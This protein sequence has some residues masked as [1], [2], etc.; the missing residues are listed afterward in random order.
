M[1]HFEYQ[2]K[3]T[4]GLNLYGQGWTPSGDLKAVVCLIHGIGEHSSRYEHVAAFLSQ[5]GYALFTFD[6]RGHGRSEG[7]HGH[8]PS[9]E[10]AMR[11]VEYHLQ[12]AAERF[13]N[14]PII[15]YG[16]SMGG[17]LVLNYALRYR[18]QIAGV[19]ATAPMLRLS[20]K[21]SRVKQLLAKFLI[22]VWPTLSLPSGLDTKDI[23]R[24]PEVV[25]KYDS[26]PLTHNRVTPCFLNLLEAGEW[27]LE[28]AAEFSKPL[29]VMHGGE[30]HITSPENSRIFA[31]NVG[32]ICTLK[33]WDGLYH[34]IH[35]EPEKEMVLE[36]MLRWIE[37]IL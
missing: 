26:D 4:D 29:L 36:T 19:I 30:D 37:S 22:R 23:S 13:Q 11:D 2:W 24:D 7:P 21:P 15:L 1:P 33:I 6:H 25:K 34:E 8:F 20:F 3:T 5:N 12:Q 14:K 31:K 10:T 32:K 17:N 27:A 16:H 28:H 35:N 9:Y 18:P